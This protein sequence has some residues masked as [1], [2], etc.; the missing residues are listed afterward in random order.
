MLRKLL[1]LS[2][3]CIFSLINASGCL[4]ASKVRIGVILRYEYFEL[5]TATKREVFASLEKLFPA[6]NYQILQNEQLTSDFEKAM[7]KKL[8][9]DPELVSKETL[10]DLSKKYK[11]DCVLLLSYSLDNANNNNNFLNW[12]KN[13]QVT[14]KVRMMQQKKGNYIYSN[15]IMRRDAANLKKLK[16]FSEVSD[17]ASQAAQRCNEHLFSALELPLAKRTIELS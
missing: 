3:I 10:L 8:L 7:A 13:A 9:K 16:D 4:A 1:F 2:L 12:Q 6:G 5:N 14:L 17:V 11:Y 15:D